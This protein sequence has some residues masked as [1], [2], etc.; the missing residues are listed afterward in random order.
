MIEYGELTDLENDFITVWA[1]YCLYQ[2][3][4]RVMPK[5]IKL[6]EKGQVNAIS[7]WYM[8]KNGNDTNSIIDTYTQCLLHQEF[9][10][11]SEYVLLSHYYLSREGGFREVNSRNELVQFYKRKVNRSCSSEEMEQYQKLRDDAEESLFNLGFMDK[12]LCALYVLKKMVGFQFDPIMQERYVEI[13]RDTALENYA[14]NIKTKHLRKQLAKRYK[15]EPNNIQVKWSLA[16][17]LALYGDNAKQVNMGK[18]L[19]CELSQRELTS[20]AFC[21][22]ETQRFVKSENEMERSN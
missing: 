7:C 19:L 14:M 22:N 9:V 21:V 1:D 4:K 11:Y 10:T 5:L 13:S 2:D 17:N 15:E 20:E 6:A 8:L 18:K 3:V 16:K 12:G